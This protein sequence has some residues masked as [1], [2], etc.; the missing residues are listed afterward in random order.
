MSVYANKIT[1]EIREDLVTLY[2]TIF[3][4]DGIDIR[5]EEAEATV[6]EKTKRARENG[7]F[8]RNI[9]V[10]QIPLENIRMDELNVQEYLQL[11]YAMNMKDRDGRAL[12]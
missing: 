5:Q 11:H 8:V 4:F 10:E 3:T 1:Y 2:R 7:H 6:M 9:K 12:F